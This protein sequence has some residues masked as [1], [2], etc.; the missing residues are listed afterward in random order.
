MGT[1]RELLE[2]ADARAP[3]AAG[4]HD[5]LDVEVLEGERVEQVALPG[6]GLDGERPTSAARK[7]NFVAINRQS[8]ARRNTTTSV[9]WAPMVQ[10]PAMLMACITVVGASSV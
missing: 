5:L 10:L 1:E 2:Y 4:A 3:V 9:M 8:S 7:S 6:F